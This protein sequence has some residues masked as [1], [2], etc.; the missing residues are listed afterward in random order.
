MRDKI[1]AYVDAMNA[2]YMRVKLD[3]VVSLDTDPFD[4]FKSTTEILKTR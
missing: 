3:D 2:K 4:F 1:Q